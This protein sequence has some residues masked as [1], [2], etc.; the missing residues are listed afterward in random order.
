LSAADKLVAPPAP[1][2]TPCIDVCTMDEAAGMCLGC[3]RTAEEIGAWLE[4]DAGF[5]RAV[6]DALPARRARLQMPAHRLPWSAAESAEFMEAAL[7]SGV[8]R[9]RLGI[10]GA[11]ADFAVGS[12]ERAKISSDA[13]AI[14]AV[15]QRGA[16]RLLKHQKTIA[17]AFG[18]RVPPTAGDFNEKAPSPGAVLTDLAALS[19][20]GRGLVPGKTPGRE[21]QPAPLSPLPPRERAD[22]EGGRVRGLFAEVDGHDVAASIN[23]R[24]PGRPQAEPGSNRLSACAAASYETNGPRLDGR[25]DTEGEAGIGGSQAIGFVLP[26]GRVTL[27]KAECLTPLGADDGAI[28]ESHRDARHYDTGLGGGLAARICLRAADPQFVVRLDAAAGSQLTERPKLGIGCDVVIE[29]GL[30]RAEIFASADRSWLDLDRLAAA[31]EMPPGWNLRPV[32][33]L[34]A[35]FYPG[36]G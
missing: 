26:R 29:T 25:G 5:K 17:I 12:D 22:A 31:R 11:A 28:L 9:W 23:L 32:F 19:R 27:E 15:S 10:H 7:R 36:R 3:A 24:R 30:G 34:G 35:L 14:T 21:S 33:A 6:W 2:P 18:N 8:G 13:D 4:A 20:E 1:V 16:L